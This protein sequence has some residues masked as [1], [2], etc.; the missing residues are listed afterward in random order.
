MH[1]GH[2]HN[3]QPPAA[4]L[5]PTFVPLSLSLS[6]SRTPC[7][8]DEAKAIKAC[9][10]YPQFAKHCFAIPTRGLV[11]VLPLPLW[12]GGVDLVGVQ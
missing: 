2:Q 9:M 12:E 10:S 11:L 4:S 5:L 7:R 1:L 3:H 6:F 8:L